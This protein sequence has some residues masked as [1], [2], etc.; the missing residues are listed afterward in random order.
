[1]RRRERRIPA[2]PDRRNGNLDATLDCTIRESR[3]NGVLDA[4]ND[5]NRGGISDIDDIT[6]ADKTFIIRGGQGE[7]TDLL[8]DDENSYKQL[9]FEMYIKGTSIKIAEGTRTLWDDGIYGFDYSGCQ[10]IVNQGGPADMM[11]YLIKGVEGYTDGDGYWVCEQKEV[12][13]TLKVTETTTVVES[14]AKLFNGNQL[15]KNSFAIVKYTHTEEDASSIR[16]ELT[17]GATI[18]VEVK[19]F[20]KAGGTFKEVPHNGG[21]YEM[22]HNQTYYIF[23]IV[24]TAGTGNVEIAAYN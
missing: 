1:M 13:V 17:E 11:F 23:V 19:V 8:I 21:D 15:N 7:L 20:G 3:I 22:E 12:S 5:Y 14:G 4:E 2:H 24:T 10:L 6:F 9:K 18:T 16:L